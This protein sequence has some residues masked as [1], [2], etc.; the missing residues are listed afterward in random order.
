MD[1]WL[2]KQQCIS[3]LVRRREE[4]RKERKGTV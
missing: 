4:D 2:L 1:H 3:R